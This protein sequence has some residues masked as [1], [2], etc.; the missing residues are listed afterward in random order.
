MAH[1][2]RVIILKNFKEVEMEKILSNEVRNARYERVRSLMKGRG[3]DLLIAG[4]RDDNVRFFTGPYYRTLMSDYIFFP[5]EGDPSLLMGA[6]GRTYL[7]FVYDRIEEYMWI[8]DRKLFTPENVAS[9]INKFEASKGTIAIA[10]LSLLPQGVYQLLRKSFPDAELIDGADIMVEARKLVTDEDI[11]ILEKTAD[12]ADACYEEVKRITKPGVYDYEVIAAW[13]YLAKSKFN[14]E[15]ALVNIMGV[16]PFDPINGTFHPT[17]PHFIHFG[18][19]VIFEITPVYYGYTIQLAR[20]VAIGENKKEISELYEV[21]KAAH[22][23]GVEML[24]PGVK[25]S[26]VN[27]A[28]EKVIIDAGYLPTSVTKSG[29]N[30]HAMGFSIDAGTFAN[31]NDIVIYPGHVFVIHPS[32]YAKNWVPGKPSVFGPG[33]TYLVTESGARRLTHSSQEQVVL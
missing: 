31:D 10:D 21:T 12:I 3:V 22:R 18:D 6:L 2:K 1:F 19:Q 8:K 11:K 30:G 15:G 25:M 23:A 16:H 26:E 9:D 29:P 4:M 20:Q 28:M 33:D 17:V 24:R 13:E 7:L 14:Y 27:K 5:K 32:A